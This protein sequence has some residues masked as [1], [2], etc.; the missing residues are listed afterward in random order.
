MELQKDISLKPYNTF[1][2]EV[3]ARYFATFSSVAE[4]Q[5]L[6]QLPEVQN[7]PK[8][9]LGG[10][11]NILFTQD[12]DG[13]ILKNDILGIR[14]TDLTDDFSLVK[15]GSGVNWHEL[16]LY[17]IEQGLGGLE[18][19]SLIPGTVGAA[20]LQNIGAY[21]VE[22]KDMFE[23]LEAV[24]ISTGELKSF[25]A[26]ECKFGY[27]ESIFKHEA[28]GQYI[29]VSVTLRLHR[30]PVFNTSYGAITQT[31]AAMQV[32]NLN[33]KVI[34]EAVCQIRRSKLPDPA[35][36]GN[37]GSFFKNPE[38]PSTQFAELQKEY[39]TIPSYPTSPGRVK[40]PAGWLI[41]QAGWKGRRFESYGVHKD[42]ALVLVNYGGAQGT[43]VR[44]LAFQIIDSVQE[45]FGIQLQPEV[46]IL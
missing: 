23:N 10:G 34:S 14:I 44:E 12:F 43:Q 20:P 11:S 39:S 32:E 9:I 22:L 26:E 18:N 37:A 7:L 1:G 2:M 30:K 21:G 6:L 36:V 38:I 13:V 5:Q 31:L 46:N 40:V 25:T 28:K 41:E 17:T 8:L 3:K 4:L 16:V 35:Q 19:L 29:I 42:Q 33:P 15:A 24:H 45:K 27:R